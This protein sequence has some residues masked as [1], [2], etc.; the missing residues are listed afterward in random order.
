MDQMII[1]FCSSSPDGEVKDMP[2]MDIQV[3]KEIMNP[4]GQEEVET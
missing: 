3:E 1:H 4:E 2:T